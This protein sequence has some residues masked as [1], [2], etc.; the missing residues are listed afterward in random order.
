MPAGSI[1]GMEIAPWGE[2]GLTLHVRQEP[3]RCVLRRSGLAGRHS[4]DAQRNRRSRSGGERRAR[5][6]RGEEFRRRCRSRAFF[7][8]PTRQKFAGHAPADRQHPRRTGKPSRGR[9]SWAATTI[10]STSS[11]S[12]SS[13]RTCVDRPDTGRRSS[14]ST[15]DRSSAKTRSRTSARSSTSWRRTRDSTRARFAVTGG[16]YGGYMCYASAVFL[17]R[18]P[19]RR[20]LRRR[21]L[22]L[23][24]VPRKHPGLPARSATR[25]IRRRARSRSSAKNCW[26]FRRSRASTK[27]RVPMLVVTGA[28]D[29]R[30]PASEADQIVKAVRAKDRTAW[31][32]LGQDEGHGFAKKVESGLPVLDRSAVLATDA[33]RASTARSSRPNLNARQWQ[34]TRTGLTDRAKFQPVPRGGR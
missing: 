14:A 10:C 22:E 30:V 34:V 18:A 17:R 28:N 4:L 5:A 12:R 2:I 11:A 8:G 1:G 25:R 32:L 24:D 19:A 13:I 31:H 29:P 16:S 27:L 26:K 15:T 3:G 20:Q 23:R 9:V 7:T 33:A 6:D 21:Y